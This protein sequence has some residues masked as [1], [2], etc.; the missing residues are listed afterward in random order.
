VENEY[1]RKEINAEKEIRG[2]RACLVI[3]GRNSL[4]N[5]HE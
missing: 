4:K 1:Q 5:G 2:L 3:V